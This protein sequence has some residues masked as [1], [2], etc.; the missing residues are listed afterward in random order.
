MY[1]G[2]TPP[3]LG[4]TPIFAISFWA[5]HI[6]LTLVEYL[7]D[8]SRTGLRPRQETG[9]LFQP[10][11]DRASAL[12]TRTCLCRCF[13]CSPGHP[14]RC[15]RRASQSPPPSMPFP[16]FFF[17]SFFGHISFSLVY[18]INIPNLGTRPKWRSSL[19]WCFRRRHQTLRRGW[20]SFPLPRDNCYARP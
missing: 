4:V 14:R 19:Q 7:I 5:S 15:P 9:V 20:Y 16:F 2:V 17:F 10:R 12:H 18:P 11:Q 6:F 3:I 13:Q 1:R 8:Q